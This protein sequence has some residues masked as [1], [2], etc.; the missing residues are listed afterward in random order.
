MTGF[1]AVLICV[2]IAAAISRRVQGTIIT[3]PMVYT[4]MGLILSG[5]VLGIIE[6]GLDNEL[7]RLVAE[8]TL[9][10][11]L[12]TDASRIDVRWLIKDHTLPLRLLAIGLP[13]MMFLGTLLAALMFAELNFWEAAVLA[14]ILAPTDASL[15]QAV[16]ANPKVPVRIRQT[17]NVESGLNDGIAV[18][19]LLLAL[20]LAI[21]EGEAQDPIFWIGVALSQI[22]FGVLAGLVIG[23]AGGRF[24][25]WGQRSGWMSKEFQKISTL[26]LA[27]LVYGA[28]EAVGGN[29]FIA[30]FVMG[31]TAANTTRREDT[32]M[33]YEYA[34]VE[35][36]G[37]MM[38]TFMI[39]FGAVMLPLALD[40][41]N[42]T[43]LLYAV[44]SLAVVRFVTVFLSMIGTKVRLVTVGFLGWFGPRGVASILY[45]FT[46]LGEGLE[47]ESLMYNVVMLT[48]L[49][50]IFAHGIT[51]APGARWYARRVEEVME[52]DGAEM[53]KVMEMP[54]RAGHHEI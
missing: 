41:F 25:E 24:I 16:V 9:V 45:I 22:V 4:V 13:L 19:F 8:V 49:L 26:T 36:Q 3:L 32:E 37:L 14:I 12:A 2:L 39:V 17:L 10:L 44:L 27:L 30:A 34:E 15:G 5:R 11:V 51:A 33:L 29:G 42:G 21:A 20:S 1:L 46:V 50:S 7:V 43:M 23:F 6:L 35:V 54:L 38:L 47:D 18:P 48:V 28:A 31:V 52:P 40:A 53:A